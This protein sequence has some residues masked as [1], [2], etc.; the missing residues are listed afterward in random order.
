MKRIGKILAVLITVFCMTLSCGILAAC[1]NQNKPPKDDGKTDYSVSVVMPDKS[2]AEGVGV[3]FRNA[4]PNAEAFEETFRT[5]ADG[6]LVARLKEAN[7]AVDLTDGIPQGY[8]YA[9][10]TEYTANWRRPKNTHEFQ[11]STE[12]PR[13]KYTVRVSG[14][15]GAPLG[16]I[17]VNRASSVNGGQ[18]LLGTTD[19]RG[20]LS[21][22][23]P[24]NTDYLFISAPAGYAYDM[25][26]G[27]NTRY[28]FS[29]NG[30]SVNFFLIKNTRFSPE[31]EMTTEEKETFASQIRSNAFRND[32]LGERGRNA[33][34]YTCDVKANEKQFF[35]FIPAESGQYVLYADKSNNCKLI[36]FGTNSYNL[37]APQSE[38]SLKSVGIALDCTQNQGFVF[39]LEGG[40]TPETVQLVFVN[41][42]E[43]N[44]YEINAPGVVDAEIRQ[45]LPAMIHFEPQVNG[46][47]KISVP[48]DGSYKVEYLAHA[49]STAPI[50]SSNEFINADV[51]DYNLYYTDKDGNLTTERS[52]LK[53]YFRI[54]TTQALPAPVTV[55]IERTG[56][57]AP[58]KQTVTV[59]ADQPEGLTQFGEQAGVLTAVGVHGTDARLVK[60][61]DGY[62]HLNA[63]E[64]P[65]V[66]VKLKGN[67][68][69]YYPNSSFEML[70][71]NGSNSYS[72]NVSDPADKDD[73][74]KPYV[75]RHYGK[76]LRGYTN[77]VSDENSGNSDNLIPGTPEGEYYLKYVNAD[78]VYPLDD[79]LKEF[80]ELFAKA[81]KNWLSSESETYTE[82]SLW[83][84]SAFYYDDGTPLPPI[85]PTVGDGTRE[86]PYIVDYGTYL[87]RIYANET[88]YFQ[89][90]PVFGGRDGAAITLDTE[91]GS[92]VN[93]SASAT[94]A[95]YNESFTVTATQHV[96]LL[97]N[98]EMAQ[99]TSS[100][101][102]IETEDGSVIENVDAK[103]GK[104]CLFEAPETG[105]YNFAFEA[106]IA[107]GGVSVLVK[108]T[109]KGDVPVTDVVMRA[110]ETRLFQ[111]LL[112]AA[113]KD[114][115]TV[116]VSAKR[117]DIVTQTPANAS[118]ANA[119]SKDVPLRIEKAN[120]GTFAA[121]Y[122]DNANVYFTITEAGHYTLTSTDAS[123]GLVY[124]ND[125]YTNGYGF[126][127][128]I[129]VVNEPV[130]FQLY[131]LNYRAATLY[132]SV[133][134]TGGYDQEHAVELTFANGQNS[135]RGTIIFNGVIGNDNN[136]D[137]KVVSEQI[138]Y[139]LTAER[140]GLYEILFDTNAVTMRNAE[141]IIVGEGNIAKQTYHYH[142]IMKAGEVLQFSV[143]VAT[144][145]FPAS[146]GYTLTRSEVPPVGAKYNP[147][148]A[149]VGEYNVT[150]QAGEE[151]YFT[152]KIGMEFEIE[153]EIQSAAGSIVIYNLGGSVNNDDRRTN[154]YKVTTGSTITG[155]LETMT[156]G[157]FVVTAKSGGSVKIILK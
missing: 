87:L 47:Y 63:K 50:E 107:Q 97:L 146:V 127:I 80:L 56:D 4:D 65:I 86:N 110:G 25:N 130:T 38:L 17:T 74:T 136:G 93:A 68:P 12:S 120:L 91:D 61:T 24:A 117:T 124:Q 15:A 30:G 52:N 151:F 46:R 73:V 7:Y 13:V 31:K 85:T 122:G 147:Q 44:D 106:S 10:E 104:W 154:E 54:T 132:F 37:S 18:K 96:K 59:E 99:G 156:G 60:G 116:T 94:Q 76:F 5:G 92:P 157:F 89:F 27:E 28:R 144:S 35:T 32:T 135:V 155:Y 121:N 113:Y 114:A 29:R 134:E 95:F 11:L 141:E 75:F 48:A 58:V 64:G 123:A 51:Y 66:V 71:I 6:K 2:P 129:V 67:I 3:T 90:I 26:Y 57:P 153:L 125:R 100:G 41:P 131:A 108:N 82:D 83:L 39:T 8:E 145:S 81:N 69:V 112:P 14:P 43:R 102:P 45:Y 62:Y 109:N 98:L 140:D 49:N 119:G 1:S 103:Y 72:F 88:K 77:M 70:D 139:K 137:K 9:G 105:L 128:G 42:A 33:Y 20:E 126:S 21:L 133:T 111:L 79:A 152:V 143:E 53:L 115:A 40:N 148:V 34:S 19:E 101:N 16:G 78:G 142:K 118:D 138:Y 150:L 23:I 84:F 55:T 149:A 22:S 36:T